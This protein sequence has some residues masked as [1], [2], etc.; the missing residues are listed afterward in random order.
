MMQYLM[1]AYGSSGCLLH[2]LWQEQLDRIRYCR[3]SCWWA[4]HGLKWRSSAVQHTGICSVKGLGTA[5]LDANNN[6][7]EAVFTLNCGFTTAR[8]ATNFG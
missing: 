4:I 6:V 5:L 7:R 1:F 8:C 2:R 3:L